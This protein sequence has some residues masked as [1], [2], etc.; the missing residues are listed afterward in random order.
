MSKRDFFKDAIAEAKTVKEVAIAN[1]KLALEESF[2]PQL[3]SILAQRIQE[4]DNEE[5]VEENIENTEMEEELDLDEILNEMETEEEDFNID[6]MLAEIEKL[7]D[8]D[9]EE[10]LYESEEEESEEE[11][12]EPADLEDMTDDELKQF[13]EDVIEDMINSGELEA[14]EGMKDDEDEDIDLDIEDDEDEDMDIEDDEE[15]EITETRF[16]RS[17]NFSRPNV[18]EVNVIR[19]ELNEAKKTITH[20]RSTISEVN[21]LN[22]KLLYTNKIFKAKNLTENEKV[23][24]LNSFDKTSTVKET[25]L[26]YETLNE[27]LKVKKPLIKESLG[28]ASKVMSLQ[29]NKKPIIEV[30]QQYS[31]WQKLAGLI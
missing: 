22:A 12:E 18:R 29:E 3:K 20:L 25:K 9:M 10:D 8:T 16:N 6:E 19:A 2:T 11:V 21:L 7:E 4:M 5:E 24:V 17:P 13:I 31:R 27:G 15:M 14:G 23:K 28:T 30:D 1:A 26:V